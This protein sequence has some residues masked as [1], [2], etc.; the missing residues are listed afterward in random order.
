[1]ETLIF[2]YGIDRV[3]CGFNPDIGLEWSSQAMTV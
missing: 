1:M 2:T 3:E